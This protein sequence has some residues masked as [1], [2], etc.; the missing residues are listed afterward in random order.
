MKIKPVLHIL[1]HIGIW[2]FLLFFPLLL[3]DSPKFRATYF[4]RS[5]MPMSFYVVVFYFNYFYLIQNQLF[6][7]KYWQFV[8]SNLAIIFIGALTIL[9][10]YLLIF[11]GGEMPETR[12]GR[13]F[14]WML[15]VIKD[16][17]FC[18]MIAGFSIAIRATNRIFKEEKRR[19]KE[20]SERLKSELTYLKYQLQPHFFFNTLNNIY[21]LIDAFPDR[22]KDTV[23]KLSKLM[24]YILYKSEDTAVGL[25][26]EMDFIRNYVELMRIRYAD[27]VKIE[28]HLVDADLSTKVPPLLIVP[29][30]E[31]AFKHGVDATQ[32]SKILINIQQEEDLLN[33]TIENSYFPKSDEDESGSGIGLENLK[34]RLD[35]LYPQ[36][37]YQFSHQLKEGL[38]QTILKIKMQN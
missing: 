9:Y 19:E 13:P 21:A 15:V 2:A 22:A 30:L 25:K 32:E 5:I 23:L 8:L 38:Y 34:K 20:E 36:G 31:N 11:H 16:V 3:I 6:K 28:M 10:L 18:S 37:D 26:Q 17:F 24:R 14:P 1:L 12:K 29:L 4:E 35:L 33:I 27:H 7:R